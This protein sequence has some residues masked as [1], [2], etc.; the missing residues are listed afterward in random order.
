MSAASENAPD[1]SAGEPP[2]A[3][4]AAVH[5]AP[6]GADSTPPFEAGV[7]ARNAAMNPPDRDPPVKPRSL[8]AP[9]LSAIGRAVA[10]VRR[11]GILPRGPRRTPWRA[12]LPQSIAGWVS[13]SVLLALF[14]LYL[15]RWYTGHLE[16]LFDPLLQNDDV[17]TALLP[18]HPYT[19]EKALANDPITREM[20]AFVM[21]GMW[22]IYRVAVPLVG[23]YHASKVAQG[24]CILIIFAAGFLLLRSRRAGLASAVL[25]VF[26][27]LHTPFVVNRIA[28]GFGRGFTFALFALWLA[29]AITRSEKPRYVACL[30]G[31][32]LQPNGVITALAL[33]GIYSV[34]DAFGRSRGLLLGRLKRYAFVV[35]SCMALVLPFMISQSRMGHLHTLTEAEQNPGFTRQGRQGELPFPDP[36]PTFANHA[37]SPFAIAGRPVARP[38]SKFYEKIGS[39]GPM[40]VFTLLLIAGYVR[41]APTARVAFVFFAASVILYLFARVFAFR[42]YSPERYYSF[43]MPMVSISLAVTTLGLIGP[44]LAPRWRSVVRNTCAAAAIAG[45]CMLAGDGVVKRNGMVIDGR[46]Q[47]ALYAFVRTLPLDIRIGCHPSDGDNIPWWT[48]RA[49]TGG[50]ETIQVWLVEAWKRSEALAQETFR[51]LYSTSKEDLFVYT[52]KHHVTHLLLRKDR[53]GEDFKRRV[54]FFEPLTSFAEKLVAP[55]SRRDLVLAN[56]P[57]NAVV[58]EDASYRLVD[59]ALL[60]QAWK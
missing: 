24:L 41:A 31:A 53:Y 16:F 44:R 10:F 9:A 43:G 23:I 60:E 7:A 39:T 20:T 46:D 55:L 30:I 36:A 1:S 2:L 19:P 5:P 34:G 40:V 35:V 37:V 57:R 56:V 29:G 17:R 49:T 12:L 6:E 52:N 13:A 18:F 51:A 3:S 32:V 4:G 45:L 14:A 58:Y 26:F 27:F 38:I 54:A 15:H 8:L 33:E 22:V 59:V 42:L 21:P 28:G 11:L 50:Y 25:L 48:G 47:P